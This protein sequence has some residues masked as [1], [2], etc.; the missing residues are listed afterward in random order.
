[1][2]PVDNTL[3]E[4]LAEYTRRPKPRYTYHCCRIETQDKY[5]QT[6]DR[7]DQSAAQNRPLEAAPYVWKLDKTLHTLYNKEQRI[8]GGLRDVFSK[9]IVAMIRVSIRG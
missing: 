1:M 5:L 6:T 3:L 4:P 7:P 2:Q 9:K 8:S